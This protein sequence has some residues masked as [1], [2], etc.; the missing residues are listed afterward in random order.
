MSCICKFVLSITCCE[1]NVL[2]FQENREVSR[3]EGMRF[4]RRHQT[5][6]IESS[7]KT[8]DGVQCAFEELVQK[9]NNLFLW[10]HG[11]EKYRST[12]NTKIG[13]KRGNSYWKNEEVTRW[14]T[15]MNQKSTQK[16]NWYV[17]TLTDVFVNHKRINVCD[18]AVKMAPYEI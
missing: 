14:S 10:P 6:F 17:L 12:D 9:V 18:Q 5:L 2:I 3:E 11:K 8:R 4:A 7:A 15:Q 13:M 16:L 1:H